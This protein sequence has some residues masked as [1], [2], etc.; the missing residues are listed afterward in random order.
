MGVGA[1]GSVYWGRG[2]EGGGE[3]KWRGH[4]PG[5]RRSPGRVQS[6]RSQEGHSS[7][8]WCGGRKSSSCRVVSGDWGLESAAMLMTGLS[9]WRSG[10][11]RHR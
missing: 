8:Q 11:F 1:G 10:G 9:I 2:R 3:I 7:Q 5:P 4:P 6:Q